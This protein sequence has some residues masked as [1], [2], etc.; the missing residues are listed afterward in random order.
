LLCT[1]VSAQLRAQRPTESKNTLT[2]TI[3]NKEDGQPLAAVEIFA[4]ETARVYTTD[5][6]GVASITSE[7]PT[8]T[9]T[10]LATGFSSLQEV[11]TFSK[12]QLATTIT[13][14]P[15]QFDLSAVTVLAEGEKRA[16]LS[17]LRA[18]EGT[19]IYAGKKT[20]VVRLDALTVNLASNQARQI[21][22]EVSGLNIYESDDAGLQLSIGGRGLDPNRSASFNTRQNGYDISADV[23]GYPESYYTPPAEA[24]S[25]VQVIRGAASLQYGTQFGG[26]VNFIFRQPNPRKKIELTSRQTIGSNGLF[27]SFNSLTGTVGKLGYYG[28]LNYK[29]GDGFRDNSGFDSRN[30]YL[31]LDYEVAENSKISF[32]YTYLDYLAQQAGGVT[33]AQF[34]ADPFQSNRTR[35][36]FEV[37]WQLYN[38]RWDHKLNDR[39]NL[40]LSLFALDASRKAVGFRTNR[41]S[42]VDDLSAPRDLIAGEFNN[43][44]AEA[45]VLHRYK[46]GGRSAVFLLGA[47]YYKASNSA[48]QG[49]GTNGSDADFQLATSGFPAFPNQSAF[50][51]PNRNVAIFG[52]HIL[53]LTDKFSLTPGIRYEYINTSSE[54]TF[55]R[56]DF[57]LAGTPIRDNEFAD[58]REFARNKVLL[59]LG[60]SYLPS[61][62]LEF[63]AN[64]SQNYRSVTFNDIR[65]VNPSFQVDPDIRDESGFTADA[66]IRGNKKRFSYTANLFALR[67]NGRLGEVLTPEV[68]V[69]A[70]G[71]ETPTGRIIRLRSNIGDAFIYGLETLLEYRMLESKTEQGKPYTLTAFANTSFTRSD[72]LSSDIAGVAG[73]EVEFIPLLNLKTGLRFGYGNLLGSVQYAY[74]SSQFTDASNANQDRR[75][76]QSGIVGEIPAYGVMDLSISYRWRKFSFE[77]GANNVLDQTYFTR[78]ATGYPGPGIIPSAPRIFYLTVG[79]TL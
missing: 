6:E 32:E 77:G 63:F 47:K 67:Y 20:E 44:G 13:L 54:G 78:R 28:Y 64:V 10:V 36:W 30:A 27:T 1:C 38:L 11:I 5:R 76:N 66:G 41:V 71:V 18:V 74:L 70:T 45:R 48:I 40:S 39:T 60:L 29:R 49:P 12:P 79:V 33:D 50:S 16:S 72:Y 62:Q 75:D 3:Q 17:R 8:L 22:A 53:Y 73:N 42:Q 19:A 58:N 24:L 31:H 68:R 25:E 34:Y 52:E 4:E 43:W 21:Y 7:S 14:T 46:L 59:G 55:R 57:D 9:L 2:L 51:F 65:T 69:D 26:L 56:I 61:E 37:D 23:L 35:N 15:L